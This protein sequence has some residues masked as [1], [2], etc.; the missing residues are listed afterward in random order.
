MRHRYIVYAASLLRPKGRGGLR[1]GDLA[2][3]SE[4]YTDPRHVLVLVPWQNARTYGTAK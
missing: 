1:A 4:L 2:A 3:G